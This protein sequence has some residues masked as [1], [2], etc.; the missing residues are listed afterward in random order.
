MGLEDETMRGILD[1]HKYRGA[2]C[3]A[4]SDLYKFES[5]PGSCDMVLSSCLP[6]KGPLRLPMSPLGRAKLDAV[7]LLLTVINN[8]LIYL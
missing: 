3:Y 6:A 4:N 5:S 2:D 1:R 7:C 8:V